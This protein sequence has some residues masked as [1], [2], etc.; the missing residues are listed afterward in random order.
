MKGDINKIID[1]L[2]NKNYNIKSVKV[3]SDGINSQVFCIKTYKQ[4][5]ALKIYPKHKFNKTK[6]LVNELEFLTFLNKANQKNI[7]SII[8]FDLNEDWILLS[9]LEGEPIYK[10]DLNHSK[11][12]VEFLT[13][14]QDFRFIPIAKSIPYASEARFSISDHIDIIY[15]RFVDLKEL[16]DSSNAM[17]EN[18]EVIDELINTS[19]QELSHIKRNSIAILGKSETTKRLDLSERIISPSDVG[20]HNTLFK[21]NNLYFY[22]F[23]YAGWDDPGKLLSDLILQPD[24]SIPLEYISVLKS[25]VKDNYLTIKFLERLPIM[26]DLYRLKW[27]A[28]LLNPI[29]K[30]KSNNISDQILFNQVNKALEY[31]LSST[32]KVSYAKSF[33]EKNFA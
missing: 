8:E 14:L 30:T 11:R 5:Y 21:N 32:D 4:K 15:R 10:P 19:N 2:K 17:K 9:W 24:H 31:S 28:I 20:F 25:F 27:V 18:I 6:R 23:E 12:L 33:F 26:L 29:Y 3:L 16:V 13:G 7:P 1:N 22:D